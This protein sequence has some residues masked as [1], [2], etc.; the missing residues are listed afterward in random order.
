MQAD[1]I[2]AVKALRAAGLEIIRTEVTPG[3][4]TFHHVHAE[5]WPSEETYEQ[6]KTRVGFSAD[7][8]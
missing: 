5:T 4:I 8:P 6:W 1:I 7:T 3:Q 2:R